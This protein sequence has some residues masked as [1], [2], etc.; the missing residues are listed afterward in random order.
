LKI[1]APFHIFRGFPLSPSIEEVQAQLQIDGDFPE[2]HCTRKFCSSTVE[3]GIP[4]TRMPYVRRCSKRDYGELRGQIHPRI[5]MPHTWEVKSMK[6]SKC[7]I[8]E[9]AWGMTNDKRK[10]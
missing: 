1:H 4:R 10:S 5:G 6:E 7:P 3:E 9:E 2:A 8:S